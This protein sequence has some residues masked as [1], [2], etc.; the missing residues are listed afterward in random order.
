MLWREFSGA[1]LKE[2]KE[3]IE[4]DCQMPLKVGQSVVHVESGREVGTIIAIHGTQAWVKDS[5]DG[6]RSTYDLPALKAK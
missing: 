2:A 1:G 4:A 3:F 6:H 5:S